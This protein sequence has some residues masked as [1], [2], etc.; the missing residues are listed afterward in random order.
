MLLTLSEMDW[1][2][3]L[4]RPALKPPPPGLLNSFAGQTILI[5][6]AGGSIGSALALRLVAVDCFYDRVNAE[7]G[8]AQSRA[9]R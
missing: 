9:V 6:G 5:T 7:F 1:R 4:A 3:F 2:E 8:Q